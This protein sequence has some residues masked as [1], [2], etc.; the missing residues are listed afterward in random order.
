M[1]PLV[2]H[3]L[4]RHQVEAGVHA[5]IGS[6]RHRA[7]GVAHHDH[8]MAV[9]HRLVRD[10]PAHVEELLEG[11][12]A[13]HPR[14]AE[15]RL[16][17]PCGVTA[18]T[19]ARCDGHRG[20]QR[21]DRLL[22]RRSASS[23]HEAGTQ[24][25]RRQVQQHRHGAVVL[26]PVAEEVRR[27]HV[28]PVARR[29]HRRQA[30]VH[31][32]SV[33]DDRGRERAGLGHGGDTTSGR[34]RG[35]QRRI[36]TDLR[37]GVDQAEAVRAQQPEAVSAGRPERLQLESGPLAPGLREPGGQ[38]HDRAHPPLAAL[39]DHVGH[40]R[41]GR[42]DD[43]QVDGLGQV[44]HRTERGHALDQLG[45]VVHRVHRTREPVGQQ[46]A[47]HLGA[48]AAAALSRAD[49]RH[50]GRCQHRPDRRRLGSALPTVHRGECGTRGVDVEADLD[51]TVVEAGRHLVPGGLED[52]EHL[53]VV[54]QRRRCEASQTVLE[55]GRDQVLEQQ[56]R[57]AP[58]VVLVVDEEGDLG[59]VGPPVPLVPG[60]RDDLVHRQ[61]D[62][63]HAVVV[64]HGGEVLHLSVRQLRPRREV[65]EVDRLR[66]LALVEP[67]QRLG[68]VG[69][70]RPDPDG[71]PVGEDHIGLPRGW[72]RS[73]ACWLLHG[74]HG[75][76]VPKGMR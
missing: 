64:V 26:G 24:V 29:H 9:G 3:Q 60:H 37:I 63:C 23:A 74:L 5:R 76:S 1:R 12:D 53:A 8:P 52:P 62:E 40:V 38:H 30:Q 72:V 67:H 59:G 69:H 10:D 50:R 48:Q 18:P 28:R 58:S 32:L 11:R 16:G 33:V 19:G 44:E 41:R 57:Q 17:P 43:G 25:A 42:G 27:G 65:A 31:P 39:I 35:G 46:V 45:V 73:G 75:A 6:Q 22:Q 2:G 68:V 15:H 20:V 51:H 21:S 54:G 56:A 36:Q 61:R 14:L 4:D 7:V 66:G 70:D 47:E 13:D 71:V 55:P 49:H 34:H